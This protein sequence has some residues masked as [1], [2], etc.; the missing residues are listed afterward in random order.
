MLRGDVT[1]LI[2]KLKFRTHCNLLYTI[3]NCYP[4]KLILEKRCI[5]F[6]HSCLSSDNLVISNVA[7]YFVILL[8]VTM[9]DILVIN[10]I[11]LPR[12]G[13]NHLLIYCRVCLTTCTVV[14]QIYL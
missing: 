4:I 12:S 10:I 9:S 13:W 5:K 6:L 11:L 7:K 3:N 14:L 1:R 2:W 8:L